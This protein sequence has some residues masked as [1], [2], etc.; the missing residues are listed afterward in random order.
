MSSL[1]KLALEAPAASAPAPSAWML[2]G[3]G[4]RR[5]SEI[6][7][8][9]IYQGVPH[10]LAPTAAVG[11]AIRAIAELHLTRISDFLPSLGLSPDSLRTVQR[12]QLRADGMTQVS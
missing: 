2:E 9:S 6:P 4:C 3:Q 5:D 10:V 1:A 11:E 8:L 12:P 7:T